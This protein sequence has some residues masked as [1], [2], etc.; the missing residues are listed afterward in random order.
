MSLEEIREERVSK[1]NLLKE[2][3]VNPYP[4]SVDRDFTLAEVIETFDEL[5]KKE[6][7][8]SV[9]GRVMA[10][11]GHGGSSFFNINDGTDTMQCYIKKDVVDEEQFE[12]FRKALDIGD[13]IE[14]KGSLF[15]TKKEE[16][17]IEVKS[18]KMISKSLLPLPDKWHGLQDTEERFRKRY[19]DLLMNDEVRGRFVLRSKA[20]SALREFL[21]SNDYLE[22]ETPSLQPLAGGA[23]AKP[24][25]THHNALDID[26]HLR[27]APELYLKELLIGGLTKVYELGKTFRNEGID[28]T[29]NPEFTILEFYEAYS[30]AKKQRAFVEK[31]FKFVASKVL[32]DNIFKHDTG[33]IDF[34]KDFNVISYGELL[35]EYASIDDILEISIEDLRLKAKEFGV[36]VSS[37]ESKDKIIDNIYKKTC[38]PKLIQPTFIIDYPVEFSPFAKQKEEDPRLIDRF[39]LVVG[40][41]ELVNAF[42]ELNDPKEQENRFLEQDKKRKAGEE[43][44][45]PSDKTY[46]EAMEYG[47]PPAGGVGIGVDRLVMLF[48]NT[49]NIREV[50]L[51]PTLRPRE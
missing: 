14:V 51:F 15:V 2:K 25:T 7:E 50:V 12:L 32:E 35:K 9:V 47:I 5:I 24:F 3:G 10:V 27:I 13:F 34:S 18:W 38:R 40:G 44:V 17:T 42:S 16:K 8:I 6:K 37:H 4:V 36:K 46:L 48:T 20:I 19:L 29:H 28:I 11:R 39:Q 49:K 31:L 45:S 23:T 1:L 30:D 21:N 43:E 26:L 41:W 22:V 33:D